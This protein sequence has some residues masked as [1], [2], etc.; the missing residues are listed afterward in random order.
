AD[1]LRGGENT[2]KVRQNLAYAYALDGRWPEARLMASQ[3]VPADQL[4]AR[5]SE[6]AHQ[7]K[8]EDYRVRV[9]GMLGTPVLAD[10]GQP[11]H[12]ALGRPAGTAL[13]VAETPAPAG[14]LPPV[15]KGESFWLAEMSRSDAQPAA[16]KP[17]AS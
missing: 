2:M 3:D 7:G 17:A 15:E 16:A 12:L 9:A 1:A 4:D 8:P 6:W 5:I 13:A 14:E 11:A 10:G